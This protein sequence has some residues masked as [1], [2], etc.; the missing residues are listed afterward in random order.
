MLEVAQDPELSVGS[1]SG[2]VRVGL[3]VRMPR[4]PA[5]CRPKTQMDAP[6]QSD[7]LDYLEE[8]IEGD[9]VWRRNYSTLADLSEQVTAVLQ[10][11]AERGQVLR[12]TEEEARTYPHLVIA[13]LGFNRTDKPTE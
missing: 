9:Q 13:S 6:T 11:Q 3:G 5:L 12:L 4:L 2:G 10:D 1:F 7:P 8:A